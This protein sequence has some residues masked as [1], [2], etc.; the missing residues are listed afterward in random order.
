MGREWCLRDAVLGLAITLVVI[1]FS[2]Q[3]YDAGNA[4]DIGSTLCCYYRNHYH[5]CLSN[6]ESCIISPPLIGGVPPTIVCRKAAQGC[7][8]PM[9][10]QILWLEG[11]TYNCSECLEKE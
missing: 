4:V 6:N 3:R 10:L 11:F 9:A 2:T 1:V 5:D 7:L 8:P